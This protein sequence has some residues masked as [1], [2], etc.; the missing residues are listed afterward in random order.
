[1]KHTRNKKW[2]EDI[3]KLA[4]E[5]PKKHKSLFFH[6]SE[7]E[8]YNDIEDLKKY[9]KYYDDYE[10]QIRLAMLVASFMDAHTSLKPIVKWIL[11]FELYCFSS[12]IYV[13]AALK[14]Y[15]KA[16]HCKIISINNVDI[17]EIIEKLK[18]MISHENEWHLKSQLP[19]YLQAMDLLYG[20]EVID[21]VDY[22]D[23]DFQD[24]EGNV[25][26]LTVKTFSIRDVN[27]SFK[28]N[29][30]NLSE[31]DELP[32]YRKNADRYYWFEYIK[33]FKILYFKYNACR[34]MENETVP[35]FTDELISFIK[36]NTIEKL[37]IDIRN[38]FGGNSTLLD[39]FI[40][41]IS[42]LKNLNHKGKLFVII[43]QETFSSAVLNAISLKEKTNAIFLGEPTGG[44]PNCYGEVERFKLD[45]CGIEISF[46]TEYYKTIED[47]ELLAFMP[48]VHIDIS[49]EDYIEKKDPCLEYL[50][51]SSIK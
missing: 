31:N 16:E 26:R 5:L 18:L 46:S 23:I 43:G 10:M 12:G 22:V 14:E 42:E 25:K 21:E 36:T 29:N 33:S 32:I 19:K 48:D 8:F 27:E 47:D 39:P 38:N 41:S 34:N 20:L 7:K 15:K 9:V 17:D 24:I 4:Y 30:S 35:Q 51:T 11:P 3:N 2:L 49:I 13:T 1:M 50:L 28:L 6:K 44:K 40:N 45:N 37:V